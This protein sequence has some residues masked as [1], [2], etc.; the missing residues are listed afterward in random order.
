MFPY[1]AGHIIIFF[2]KSSPPKCGMI[3]FFVGEVSRPEVYKDNL[4]PLYCVLP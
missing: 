2:L 3:K 4:L 1:K